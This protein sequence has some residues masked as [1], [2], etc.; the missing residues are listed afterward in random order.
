[1][2]HAIVNNRKSICDLVVN[3]ISVQNYVILVNRTIAASWSLY[4]L[5]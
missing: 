1:M 3:V 4:V 5:R 2:A